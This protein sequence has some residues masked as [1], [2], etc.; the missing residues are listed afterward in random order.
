MSDSVQPHRWQ[1]TRLPHPW[2]SPGKNPRVGCHCLLQ[3]AE[4]K[5]LNFEL[6]ISPMDS[7]Y[8][9]APN[10]LYPSIKGFSSLFWGG[11]GNCAWLTWLQSPSCNSL[12]ILNKAVF[13]VEITDS[14]FVL[15]LPC[16]PPMHES[17]M[18][19]WSRSVVSDSLWPHGLQHDRPSCLSPTPRVMQTHVHWVNILWISGIQ[20]NDL[21]LVNTVKW[22][23]QRDG[24]LTQIAYMYRI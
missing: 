21:I 13:A 11:G 18:W 3:E 20:N 6:S 7:V 9:C 5:P 24:N 4:E 22:W 14:L 10:F 2:D 23:S 17:E 8:Y 15:G 16:P 1:P 19:T 12:L